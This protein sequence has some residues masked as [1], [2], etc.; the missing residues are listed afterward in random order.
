MVCEAGGTSS[1][2]GIT[3]VRECVALFLRLAK[4]T[5]IPIFLVGHV[6]KSGEVAGPRTVEH[7]VDCVLYLEGGD[8]RTVGGVNLRMLRA[9]KNRFGSADEVG[10]YK[11][12]SGRLMPVSDP[13]SLF[14]SDHLNTEDNEGC[15]ISLTL[16]GLRAMTVEIQA[17]VTP[18]NEGSGRQT[19]DGIAYSRLQ[20]LMG[21]LRKRCRMY[22]AK[23]DIYVN[24]VGNMRLDKGEG[25]TS[26]LAVSMALVSSLLGIPVRSD[27]A[28]AGEVGL[29]GELRAVP[30][31]EKRILEARRMGFSRVVSSRD[32]K[33]SRTNG[34]PKFSK[35]QGIDWIQC[36]TLLDALNEGLVGS[37]PMKG[38]RRNGSKQSPGRTSTQSPDSVA[39]LMLDDVVDDDNDDYEDFA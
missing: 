4:S 9:A 21:V 26:D 24:V 10:V 32:K 38:T 39:E 37:L 1:A 29:L 8:H 23:Q 6:T 34:K 13:S 19:V 12:T 33:S 3:Q 31:I 25:S 15:A 28:F 30:Y 22:F 14:L 11:M 18:N 36:D 20:L 5:G 35:S 17:L 7:M 2:G 16:E 27:T